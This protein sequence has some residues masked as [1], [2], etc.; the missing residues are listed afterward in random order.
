MLHGQDLLGDGF[1]VAARL[2]TA[3][4]TVTFWDLRIR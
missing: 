1:N 4:A 3:A 2:Q